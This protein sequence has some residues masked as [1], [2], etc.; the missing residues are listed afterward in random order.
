LL[1]GEGVKHFK[2][3]V[4]QVRWVYGF[5]DP[6]HVLVL[7]HIVLDIGLSSSHLPGVWAFGGEVARAI[8]VVALLDPLLGAALERSLYLGDVFSEAL[9]VCSVRGKAP[10][11]EVH[12]D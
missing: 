2:G 7:I 8:T 11:G 10:S 3:I 1:Q 6:G 12:R 9:L 5:L 4:E